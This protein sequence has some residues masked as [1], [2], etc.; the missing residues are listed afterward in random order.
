MISAGNIT[1]YAINHDCSGE[2]REC[3]FMEYDSHGTLIKDTSGSCDYSYSDAICYQPFY[4]AKDELTKIWRGKC[5]VSA[6]NLYEC[7]LITYDANG[8]ADSQ[9]SYNGGD[10]IGDA[11]ICTASTHD[12]KGNLLTTSTLDCATK[13]V[14]SMTTYIYNDASKVVTCRNTSPIGECKIVVWDNLGLFPIR[15]RDGACNGVPTTNCITKTKSGRHRTLDT[16][17]PLRWQDPD[18][19]HLHL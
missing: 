14:D 10:C 17:H 12:A 11:D 3:E 19:Q 9:A 4:D 2:P 6:T 18:L 16:R 1:R 5:P 13:E 7:N 8:Y 15:Q